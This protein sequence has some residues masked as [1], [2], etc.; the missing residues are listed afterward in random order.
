MSSDCGG[1]VTYY[2]TDASGGA[3]IIADYNATGVRQDRYTQAGGGGVPVEQFASGA[4]YA[5]QTDAL[6][7]V[8]RITSAGGATADAY[9]YGA[10]G[11]TT[12]QSV[13]VAQ[14]FGFAGM[15]TDPTGTMYTCLSR[16]D[17]RGLGNLY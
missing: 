14:P 10:W 17:A 9:A 8:R 15:P 2:G 4:H 12:S 13:G 16:S 7:S 6:G 1:T 11:N 5:V 3:A